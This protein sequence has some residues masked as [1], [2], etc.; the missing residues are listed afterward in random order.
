[1]KV[2]RGERLAGLAMVLFIVINLTLMG[3]RLVNKPFN[4]D[5]M[6]HAHIAWTIAQGEILYRDFWDHHGPFYNLMNGALIFLTDP[7][8][9]L[10][11]LFVARS[12]SF[13]AMLAVLGLTW[14]IAR[15]LQL[16]RLTS[17]LAV[18]VFASLYFLQNKGVEA[19]PDVLQSLFWIAGL[20]LMLR[21]QQRGSW[22]RAVA[23]GV[24]FT[25][26][27]LTNAKAGIGPFF[28]VVYYLIA[29]VTL[30]MPARDWWRDMAGMALGLALTAT[31]FLAY[32]YFT[33][34]LADFFY[35]NFLFAVQLTYYWSVG[36]QS[37]YAIREA[38]L[39]VE[40]AVFFLQY[41]LPFVLATLLG[42][43]L[44]WPRVAGQEPGSRRAGALFLL[45]TV[46]T[47]A[48]WVA[49]LFSQF[50][51]IFLPLLSVF[52]AVGLT[53]AAGWLTRRLQGAG[54]VVTGLGAAA[55]AAA[56]LWYP[57]ANATFTPTRLLTEQLA[58]T[59]KFVG[60]TDRDEAVGVI[61]STCGG[62]VFNRNIGFYWV[63]MPGISELLE[64]ITGEH[65]FGEAFIQQ[66]EQQQVRYVIGR[67]DWMT[68]GLTPA[69][70]DYL[71]SR[72]SYTHC[73]WTRRP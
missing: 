70:L 60:L 20:Y 37:A 30:G 18:T 40:Y 10:R 61:W 42:V 35:Y 13:I 59:E 63:A 52:A 15:E 47:S 56:M 71:N 14:R 31:P 73:L 41:Q 51:L 48:G 16:S 38:G 28:V 55:A 69:A 12:A 66:L 27:I 29:P 33:D 1:M 9:S 68:E 32:F 72:F 2:L 50:F 8:P 53:A 46:G 22:R 34:S 64:V 19:R 67:Q 65:P 23:G 54:A 44:W 25:L 36:D 21:N 39:A 26:A 3:L 24:L 6:Q 17:L 62:Y 57:L 7:A 11:L 45:A 58:F 43:A 49:N 4:P 5:E